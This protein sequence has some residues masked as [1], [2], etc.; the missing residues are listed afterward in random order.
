MFI[1]RSLLVYDGLTQGSSTLHYIVH[2]AYE[3]LPHRLFDVSNQR[4]A[5]GVIG[6][7]REDSTYFSKNEVQCF[8]V[9]GIRTYY[10]LIV[11]LEVM[12]WNIQDLG[13]KELNILTLLPQPMHAYVSLKNFS[14]S[15]CQAFNTRRGLSVLRQA[16]A[17]NHSTCV[18]VEY[19]FKKNKL[20]RRHI[21]LSFTLQLGLNLLLN[22]S[23]SLCTAFSTKILYAQGSQGKLHYEKILGP[24]IES[25]TLS[26]ILLVYC[27]G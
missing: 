23:S 24:S 15:L 7:A 12:K 22:I 20:N 8:T 16:R 11:S 27:F 21:L 9:I 14:L 1:G 18:I 25:V 13:W 10:L 4:L 6:V 19:I 26:M 3:C 17:Q 5:S 2:R